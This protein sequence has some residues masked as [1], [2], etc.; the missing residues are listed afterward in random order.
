MIGQTLARTELVS[1][2]EW[3]EDEVIWQKGVPHS[4]EYGKEWSGESTV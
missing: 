1:T 4:S 2:V 3:N